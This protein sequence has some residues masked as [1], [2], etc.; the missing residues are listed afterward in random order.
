M[1]SVV[2]PA[3]AQDTS[4]EHHH[5]AVGPSPSWSWTA[6]ANLFA[7]QNYQQRRFTDFATFESQNWGMLNGTRPFWRGRL[8]LEGMASLGP[9]TMEELGSPQVFQTGEAY[10]GAPLIDRQHPHDLLMELAARYT[11]PQ[12]PVALIAAGGLVGAPALGPTPFMH[13]ESAR[14]N[15]AAPLGHHY[16]D[17]THTTGLRHG[18]PAGRRADVRSVGI[19]G[20]GARRQPAQPRAAMARF[21]VRA[22]RLAERAM[23]GA[24]L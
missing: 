14:D 2:L 12:G 23:A 18:R 8:S 24:V 21:V 3:S 10:H 15:P 19:S 4:P 1:L 16:Q 22:R 9:F 17:S 13:R 6:D 20:P 11:S 5:A 7:G